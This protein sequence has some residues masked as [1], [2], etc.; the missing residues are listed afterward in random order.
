MND[1]RLSKRIVALVLMGATAVAMSGIAQAAGKGSAPNGKPFIEINGQISE[2][3]GDIKDLQAQYAAISARVDALEGDFQAKI[4]LLNSEVAALQ[5]QNTLR[6]AEIQNL[7]TIANQ[8]GFDVALALSEIQRLEAEINALSADQAALRADLQEQIDV[9]R[10]NIAQNAS[11]VQAAI[12]TAQANSNLIGMLRADITSL[13][14][15]MAGKQN[16]IGNACPAGSFVYSVRNDGTLDCATASASSTPSFVTSFSPTVD[17]DNRTED[18]CTLEVLGVCLV[19]TTTYFY[20]DR[21][22]YVYCPA[23]YFMTGGGFATSINDDLVIE[24]SRPI[25]PNGWVTFFD[26]RGATNTSGRWGQTYVR[27]MRLD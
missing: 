8:N 23:G 9:L 14:A 22:V 16:D 10:N 24:D 5:A 25:E 7:I 11:G 20:G 21:F 12:A 2:V 1:P 27:C 17:L 15:Q 4:N 6:I 13:Q 26:N 19:W 18:E 3:R